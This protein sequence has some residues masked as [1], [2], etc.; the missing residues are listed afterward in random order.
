[1]RFSAKVLVL[2]VCLM[3]AATRASAEPLLQLDIIGGHY[4]ASTQTIVSDGPVFQLVA[5][6]TPKAGETFSASAVYYISAALSPQFGPNPSSL[7]S[8]TWNNPSDPAPTRTVVATQD[9]EYGTPPIETAL[10][11]TEDRDAGDLPQ[12]S[13]YPTFF[14][15][16]QFSFLAANRTTTYN[17]ADNSGQPIVNNPTG[18]SYYQI[19]DLNVSNLS[20]QVASLHFDLYDSILKTECM[21]PNKR[22]TCSYD[23]DID[24]FAPFSHDAQS[25]PRIPPPPPP[26]PPPPVI[27]EP[28]SLVLLATGLAISA[29]SLRRRPQSK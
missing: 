7:G 4:D 12:H 6:L 29:R 1:M 9:M 15:E 3:V 19:F 24:H 10:V 21:G 23:E 5:L 26:P 20:T 16:F 28:A 17:T 27:P 13:V 8:F 14:T 25:G 11:G 18:G 2:S 22:R